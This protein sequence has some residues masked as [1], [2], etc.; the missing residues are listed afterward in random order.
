[1]F[2]LF[3]S[4]NA[5]PVDDSTSIIPAELWDGPMGQVL[6]DAGLSADDASNRLDM[7]AADAR[8]AKARFAYEQMLAEKNAEIATTH[9]G[10]RLTAQF[11]FTDSVWNGRHSDLLLDLLQMTPFD[12]W[13][14]RLVAADH[15]S[16]A[17]LGLPRVYPAEIP[18]FVDN[19]NQLMDQLVAEAGPALDRA[20]GR[21]PRSDTVLRKLGGDV[22][23][24]AG[25]LWAEHIEPGLRQ[26]G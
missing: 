4:R 11:I 26:D 20:K 13:N 2:G 5:R 24:I 9:P 3:K 19:A 17:A 1:M 16:E 22:A 10:A 15:A 12:S 21:D 23:G 8:L 14:I 25:Y 6:R 18:P 7:S